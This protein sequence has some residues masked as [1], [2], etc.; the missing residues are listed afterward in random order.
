MTTAGKGQGRH[1]LYW[2]PYD[3]EIDTEAGRGTRVVLSIPTGR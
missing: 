1:D 3:V 2:D